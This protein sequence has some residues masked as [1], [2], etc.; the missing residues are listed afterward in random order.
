MVLNSKVESG[1]TVEEETETG[2]QEMMHTTENSCNT[3]VT[4]FEKLPLGSM[5]SLVIGCKPCTALLTRVDTRKSRRHH[6][7][8]NRLKI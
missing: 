3:A 5:N 6:F 2:D 4:E 1:V 7:A 8:L